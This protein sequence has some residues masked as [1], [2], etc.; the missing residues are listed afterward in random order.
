ML[1]LR[2]E[3][4]VGGE[5]SSSS[6]W[7]SGKGADQV[8]VRWRAGEAGRKAGRC[9]T[10][11]KRLAGQ[12]DAL[13][14]VN[15]RVPLVRGERAVWR[16]A[17]LREARGLVVECGSCGVGGDALAVG[18]GGGGRKGSGGGRRRNRRLG[19]GVAPRALPVHLT[20]GLASSLEPSRSLGRLCSGFG[21]FLRASGEMKQFQRGI[22]QKMK[23]KRNEEGEEA[24]EESRL[25]SDWAE[26]EE[27]GGASR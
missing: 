6:L 8:R 26:S 19:V 11:C 15:G 18:G 1:M 16:S 17:E 25:L 10:S 7:Q 14:W 12:L 3:S 23:E 9:K 20:K 2:R 24:R 5:G 13:G 27:A 22:L 21:H 4:D